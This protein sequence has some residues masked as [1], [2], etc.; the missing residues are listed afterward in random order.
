V[1]L[2]WLVVLRL[3]AGLLGEGGRELLAGAAP[4]WPEASFGV[5][6][7][8]EAVRGVLFFFPLLLA[9]SVPT[10]S[11]AWYFAR[12]LALAA[13]LFVAIEAGLLD[14]PAALAAA[15][16]VL[17]VAVL[18]TV[19][20]EPRGRRP[21]PAESRTPLR[22]SRPALDPGRRFF[23]DRWSRPLRFFAAPVALGF[24]A[25]LSAV[26][27]E[28]HGILSRLAEEGSFESDFILGGGLGAF[29]GLLPLPL[30]Y[31]LGISIFKGVQ[32]GRPGSLAPGAYAE[33][34]SVLPVPRHRVARAVFEHAL[35]GGLVLWGLL[36]G[37]AV[38]TYTAGVFSYRALLFVLPLALAIPCGA[39]VLVGVAFGD[40]IRTAVS[41]ACLLLFVPLQVGA[42]FLIDRFPFRLLPAPDEPVARLL[43]CLILG[44][45]LAAVGGIPP[46]VHLRRGRPA[47]G[48]AS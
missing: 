19:G 35:L 13:I 34:W 40:T 41:L 21:T 8:T 23:R 9:W 16:L 15:S 5:R 27:L 36:V 47:R 37:Y 42:E 2:L 43:I 22:L 14:H 1:V 17:S 33:A 6:V 28:R 24:V 44:A 25:L 11:K 39:G 29:I 3:P 46:L 32:G 38:L 26:L 12:P 30:L 18:L 48:A 7:L 31:P 4:L 45:V 10:R 20:W